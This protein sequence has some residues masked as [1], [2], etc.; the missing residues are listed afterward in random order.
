MY[1]SNSVNAMDLG[2]D[3]RYKFFVSY[4]KK[5]Q[6]LW[7]LY[8]SG[9]AEAT[10]ESETKGLIVFPEKDT[11]EAYA[12]SDFD[13]Y[14]PKEIKLSSFLERWVDKLMGQSYNIAVFPTPIDAPKFV[15]PYSIRDD[16][17]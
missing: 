16:L 15:D 12:K 11:A 17:N 10:D 1:R 14:T 5:E 13:G 4:V 6:L 7:G 3:E 2:P 9:W 8:N